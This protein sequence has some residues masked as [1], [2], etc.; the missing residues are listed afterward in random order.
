[1]YLHSDA[2]AGDWLTAHLE[3]YWLMFHV[4]VFW[5]L[6]LD[7][8]R[9][10]LVFAQ[11][12]VTLYSNAKER[13]QWDK[14]SE[15]FAI[16]KTTEH[17]EN[18]RIKSAVGR[19]EVRRS[20]QYRGER[21]IITWHCSRRRCTRQV[22]PATAVLATIYTAGGGHDKKTCDFFP[23]MRMRCQVLPF[24]NRDVRQR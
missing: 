10:V 9:A 19:D 22:D 23:R 11:D 14:L 17:L 16:I 4:C 12:E 1:M 15:F 5:M 6:F 18:A 3:T 13:R 2:A 21:E 7:G 8:F 24:I 20:A